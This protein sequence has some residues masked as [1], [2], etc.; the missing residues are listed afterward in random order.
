VLDRGPIV[1]GVQRNSAADPQRRAAALLPSQGNVQVEQRG[2]IVVHWP[3][4]ASLCAA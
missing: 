2:R 4:A 3:G 1:L